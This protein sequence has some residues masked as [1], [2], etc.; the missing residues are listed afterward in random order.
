MK[1]IATIERKTK[2]TE[3]SLSIDLD[4]NSDSNINT[5]IPFFTHMLEL[6]ARHGSFSLS[7]DVKGDI[8]IDLHHT[9]EDTGI[10]L[11]QA[12]AQALGNKDGINRYGSMLLPMDETLI[13]IAL[14]LS[15]RPFFFWQ[16]PTLTGDINGFSIEIAKHFFHS[17]TYQLKMNMH[18]EVIRGEEPHHIIEGLFKALA[19]SLKKATEITGKG[20]PSTKGVL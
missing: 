20:I 5:P 8:E 3:I 19:R 9:I 1:R 18:M 12:I 11:G 15:G 16:A 13:R 10:V 6:F 2:E 4:N 14:D 17:L 7:C